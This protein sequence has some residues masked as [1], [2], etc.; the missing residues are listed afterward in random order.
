VREAADLYIHDFQQLIH[1][2]NEHLQ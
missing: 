1:L 2:L